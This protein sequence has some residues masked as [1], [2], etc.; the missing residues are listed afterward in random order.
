MAKAQRRVQKYARYKGKV[1]PPLPTQPFKPH[2]F[3]SE[4]VFQ[5]ASGRILTVFITPEGHSRMWHLVDMAEGEVGWFGTVKT[6]PG[7]FLI[8]EVFLM[9]QE[10][11]A[12]QIDV[13]ADGLAKLG[14]YLMET[15]DD[16]VD[17]VNRLFFHGHSHVYMGTTPSLPDERH[18]EEMRSNGCPY[19]IRAILNKHG[20]ME[21]TVFLWEAGLNVAIKDVPWAIHSP[22]D[23]SM[24]A[25]LEAEF[26]EKVSKTMPHYPVY[27]APPYANPEVG[28]SMLGVAPGYVPLSIGQV[29]PWAHNVHM[30]DH[31]FPTPAYE[32]DEDDDRD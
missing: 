20:R 24:R 16:G 10:V 19:F 32:E 1:L 11:S 18:M 2:D 6:V 21:F 23:E 30:V 12:A 25:G 9:E 4:V 29:D 26:R 5:G 13:S 15:R 8:E 27:E 3:K 22:I 17:L 14:M 7:G 28:S 31:R